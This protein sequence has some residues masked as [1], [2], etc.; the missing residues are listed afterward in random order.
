MSMCSFY[1]VRKV[2]KCRITKSR[3]SSNITESHISWSMLGNEKH[4]QFAVII[5]HV[6]LLPEYLTQSHFHVSEELYEREKGK[7][8][9]RERLKWQNMPKFI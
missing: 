5:L 8:N 7:F 1:F 9:Q 2:T 3:K 4:E 6:D